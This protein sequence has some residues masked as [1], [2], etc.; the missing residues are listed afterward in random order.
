MKS[1]RKVPGQNLMIRI[2]I[3]WLII[4]P[5]CLAFLLGLIASGAQSMANKPT[6]DPAAEP[7]Q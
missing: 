2:F 1:K 4:A 7:S 6:D 5:A 3:F